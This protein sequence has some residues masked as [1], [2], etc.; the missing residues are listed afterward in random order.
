L[1]TEGYTRY[2]LP[3]SVGIQLLHKDGCTRYSLTASLYRRVHTLFHSSFCRYTDEFSLGAS[4]ILIQ[5]LDRDS[6]RTLRYLEH[7]KHNLI[8]LKDRDNYIYYMLWHKRA[9]ISAYRVYLFVSY[10]S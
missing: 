3:A 2:Y 9:L 10:D 6:H 4:A 1:Y 8:I 7:V 5:L